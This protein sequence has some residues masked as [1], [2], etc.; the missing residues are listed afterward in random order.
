M[1]AFQA[2]FMVVLALVA[3][4]CNFAVFLIVLAGSLTLEISASRAR[5]KPFVVATAVALRQHLPDFALLVV[6]LELTMLFHG[7]PSHLFGSGVPLALWSVLVGLSI[8]I[9][10]TFIL[11]RA[12]LR[13]RAFFEH[14]MFGPAVGRISTIEIVS[15]FLLCIAV[16]LFFLMP[17]LLPGGMPSMLKILRKQFFLT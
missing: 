15:L 1:P 11:Y 5:K 10:K 17:Q 14:R 8:L 12:F 9:P 2:G 13:V 6:G 4:L 16:I 7:L 3:G